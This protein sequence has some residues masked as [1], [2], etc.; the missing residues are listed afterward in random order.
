MADNLSGYFGIYKSPLAL[1]PNYGNSLFCTTDVNKTTLVC[2]VL[3]PD[4]IYDLYKVCSVISY[5][6]IYIIPISLDTIFCSDICNAILYLRNQKPNIK[7]IYP[8]QLS[9]TVVEFEEREIVASDYNFE[10]FN[11]ASLSFVKCDLTVNTGTVSNDA[12]IIY[13]IIFFD[14]NT[15]YYFCNYY[16]AAKALSLYNNT[17]IDQVHVSYDTTLVGGLNFKQL[18]AKDVSYRSKF[19][20]HSFTDPDSY[21]LLA[22]NSAYHVGTVIYSYLT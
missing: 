2:I 17:N 4:A 21:E 9:G 20:A 3:S 8:T 18:I 10:N 12:R 19:Y 1:N 13:D 6:N 22:N 11:N 14:G 7:W 5:T 16:E 15:K